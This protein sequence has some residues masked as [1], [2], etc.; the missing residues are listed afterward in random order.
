M[1][2]L[3]L[4]W[5]YS[6]MMSIHTLRGRF[7]A[8]LHAFRETFRIR[9]EDEELVHEQVINLARQI[10]FLYL[11]L[12]TSTVCISYT[13]FGR[14]PMWLGLYIPIFLLAYCLAR[15]LQW[16]L[17][18]ATELSHSQNIGQLK[19]VVVLS[20][21][22]TVLFCGWVGGL[23]QYAGP[24]ESV[25]LIYFLSLTIVGCVF[26]VF[27]HPAAAISVTVWSGTMLAIIMLL[28]THFLYA[29]MWLNLVILLVVLIGIVRSYFA[30]N[31]DLISS[32]QA[33]LEQKVR[34][35]RAKEQAEA[36]DQAK[37][38][39]LATMSHEIRTPMNGILGMADL[40]RDS[41][42][43]DEQ[44][45]C[46]DT[47]SRSG[48]SLMR[49]LN[50]ILDH[51]KFDSGN[52]QLEQAEI[53]LAL[54]LDDVHITFQQG[55]RA[56]SLG[57]YPFVH[58]SAPLFFTGDVTRVKQT[59]QN[60]V[61]N[62]LKFTEHGHIEVHVALEASKLKFSVKDTGIG[63]DPEIVPTLFERFTQADASTTRQHGGTGLGLAICR[64]LAQLMGGD[65]GCH[66]VPGEGSTFWF[67]I[68]CQMPQY[69]SVRQ[70]GPVGSYISDP[71]SQQAFQTLITRWPELQ[72]ASDPSFAKMVVVTDAKIT[73]V[74]TDPEDVL[75]LVGSTAQSHTYE[76]LLLSP[77]IERMSTQRE[78][79]VESALDRSWNHLK[80]LVAEDNPTNQLVI[81][82][83]L[84]KMDIATTIV[85]NG[86][87]AVEAALTE[88][89]DLVFMDCEMPLLSG[90]D[91]TAQIRKT[92]LAENRAKLP[93][94]TLTAHVQDKFQLQAKAAGATDYLTKP[95]K[96]V[97]LISTIE[98]HVSPRQ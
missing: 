57:F 90:F 72:V 17:A 48:E 78:V 65:A 58:A 95:V 37:T 2:E 4:L 20:T 35:T 30:V 10:P 3:T 7:I 50:D 75:D 64:Q 96:Q 82:K 97:D 93:I 1:R 59:L 91:A 62:A 66:S 13:V 32:R 54:M 31:V 19:R 51:S 6:G 22:M 39:F 87:D 88:D 92:E 36:A 40:L 63:V 16:R 74:A 67:S 49:I 60:L 89:F 14:V 26:C 12:A 84:E 55:L 69:P 53:D 83:M 81:R 11:L 86:K 44:R 46:I 43:T 73:Q 18:R 70:A 61:S 5:A 28:Q 77:I 15:L 25:L 94:V 80:I 56:K 9:I 98:R 24:T 85:E 23:M 33:I 71:I 76:R 21:A 29:A 42:M 8:T 41:E 34:V 79:Q 47:L 27:Q 45:D 38:Q 68:A 52:M